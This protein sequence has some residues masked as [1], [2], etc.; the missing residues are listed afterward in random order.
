MDINY[1]Q[2]AKNKITDTSYTTLKEF[3]QGIPDNKLSLVIKPLPREK[4]FR[5]GKDIDI[6]L[7]KYLMR[8]KRDNTENWSIILNIWLVY[9]E[10]QQVIRNVL[11]F[12]N[13]KELEEVVEKILSTTDFY[14]DSIASIVQIAHTEGLTKETLQNWLLFSPFE[15]DE[16]ID[17]LLAIAPSNSDLA[18]KGRVTLIEKRI[19][20]LEL[21]EK[22]AKKLSEI[23]KVINNL[24][25]EIGSQNTKLKSSVADLLHLK[26][27]TSQV[28]LLAGNLNK[29]ISNT[30]NKDLSSLRNAQ[31][32]ISNKI[33]HISNKLNTLI[34][35]SSEYFARINDLEYLENDHMLLCAYVENLIKDAEIKKNSSIS[36]FENN[37]VQKDI[38]ISVGFEEINVNNEDQEIIFLDSESIITSHIEKNLNRLGIKLP[39]ARK[40]AYEIQAALATGQMVTF[41]GSFASFVAERCASCLSGGTYGLLKIPFGLIESTSFETSLKKLI[42]DVDSRTNPIAVVIE[43]INRSAFEIYGGFLK[44]IITERALRLNKDYDFVFFFATTVEGP[45]TLAAGMEILD[46][47][48]LFSI[49]SIG[50]MDKPAL[51]SVIGSIDKSTWFSEVLAPQE[52]YD[53]EDGILPDWLLMASSALWRKNLNTADSYGR[54]L[55]ETMN[56]PYEFNL[57]GWVFPMLL[58]LNSS[59]VEEFMEY[60]EMDDRLK[61]FLF[62]KAPEVI[63]P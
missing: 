3:I 10:G 17:K 12:K 24:Q 52:S 11:D 41:E 19:N 63:N 27:K 44:K 46:Y 36:L 23:D 43:G 42:K 34:E 22:N 33:E 20:A 14:R 28:E 15:P 4:G 57:F 26:E 38:T 25:Q 30:M 18:L 37:I 61:L 45:S 32:T 5:P 49:D 58:Q 13:R 21:D 62:K 2:L 16:E 59:R 35:S 54:K 9:T 56:A 53:L 60:L 29:A 6:R 48:P 1:S 31:E 40:L 50:W 8:L 47:G 39:H 7:Q 55:I 51:S